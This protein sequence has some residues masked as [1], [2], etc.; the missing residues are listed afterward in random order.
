M[1]GIEEGRAKKKQLKEM[2]SRQKDIE[3]KSLI[4]VHTGDGKGKTTAAMGMVFRSVAHGHKV[5]IV[6]FIKNADDFKYGEQKLA[7]QFDNLDIF[8]M[9]AGFTWDTENKELDIKTTL[10]TWEKAKELVYSGEYRM[11]LLD[12]INYVISYGYLD[13]KLV[14][15]LLENK[16]ARMHLVL[17]GRGAT[18]AIIARADLVTEMKNIKHPFEKGILAQK[19]IEW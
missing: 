5:A 2:R 15:E 18:E 7:K 17:T 1:P 16:P 13:E 14:L 11:V 12:E 3:D 4:I 19:G 10:Q 6:Q 9:G 8:T